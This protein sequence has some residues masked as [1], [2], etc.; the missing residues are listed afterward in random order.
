MLLY[1]LGACLA[2]SRTRLSQYLADQQQ[3]N[4]PALQ[5]AEREE[6]K[7]SL[8]LTQVCGKNDD[9]DC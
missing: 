1:M 3:G 8:V 4:N 9:C 5:D 2:A 6:L 7:N